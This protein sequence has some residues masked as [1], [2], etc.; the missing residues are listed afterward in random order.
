MKTAAGH[1]LS[2]LM[3]Q[4]GTSACT[5]QVREGT[6]LDGKLEEYE[7]AW[8]AAGGTGISSES[9]GDLFAKL[10]Q[11]LDAERLAQARLLK[12]ALP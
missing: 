6:L 12:L 8:Q 2:Y 11:P 7:A 5:G 3:C 1:H 4:A 10:G 9:V